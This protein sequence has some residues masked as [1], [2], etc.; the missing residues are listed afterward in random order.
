[1]KSYAIDWQDTVVGTLEDDSKVMIPRD[2]R[3][4]D[5]QAFLAWQK[6]GGDPGP[7]PAAPPPATEDTSRTTINAALVGAMADNRAYLGL[8]A[9]VSTA[10]QDKAQ[11]RALTRQVNA[12]IRLQLTMLNG[13]D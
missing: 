13:T 1:M 9:L 7:K 12:L 5:Y 4:R 6:A 10:A 8:G 11:V 3:N 2:P